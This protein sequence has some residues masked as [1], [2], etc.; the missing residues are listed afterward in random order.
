[1]HVDQQHYGAKGGYKE[2][3]SQDEPHY[4]KHTVTKPIYQEVKEVISP[5]RKVTQVV[6]P[7]KVI[8]Y[9]FAS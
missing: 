3:H 1:M 9:F 8:F 7:V 6:E 2:S 5:Y 4:L